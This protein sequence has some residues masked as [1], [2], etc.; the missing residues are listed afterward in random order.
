MRM[1]MGRARKTGFSGLLLV[2]LAEIVPALPTVGK[3][4]KAEYFYPTNTVFTLLWPLRAL[5][6]LATWK[7]DP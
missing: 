7:S 6:R 3:A 5:P 2:F 1:E 4:K